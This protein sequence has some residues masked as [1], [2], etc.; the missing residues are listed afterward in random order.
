MQRREMLKLL[1]S[2]ATLSVIPLELTT[3]LEQAWAQTAMTIGMR[4]L[5]PHQDQTVI[6]MSE[7]IIPETDT[8][9]AKGAK[10][11]EFLDLLLTEWFDKDQADRFV[12]GIDGVDTLSKKRFGTDFVSSTPAQQ[13]ELM[14]QMDGEAA[15]FVRMQREQ[16]K[17]AE[18]SGKGGLPVK[19]G[20]PK[21]ATGPYN[22]FYTF[23]KLTIFGYYTTKIGFN[24]ELGEEIIPPGHDGCAP[25]PERAR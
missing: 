12:A 2:V 17:K 3:G 22:F 24:Q 16:A 14:K 8:P 13:N 19:R 18:Q 7:M 25:L 23:K 15:E 5:S 10:V 11:N 20:R 6:A 1:T 4:T 9:G 21:V